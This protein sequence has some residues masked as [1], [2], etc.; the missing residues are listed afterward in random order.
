MRVSAFRAARVLWL[1]VPL[2]CSSS[3]Q[4]TPPPAPAPAEALVLKPNPNSVLSGLLSFT[5]PGATSARIVSSNP[6]EQLSTPY[7]AVDAEGRGQIAV[8][9]LA[10][11]TAYV[12]GVQTM[13]TAGATRTEPVTAT[14]TTEPL[15]PEI[16]Q[17]TI[18]I[19]PG[20][21]KPQQGYYVVSGAGDDSYAVDSSGAIRWYRA[22]GQPSEECKMQTDGTFTSYVGSSTGSEPVPGTYVRYTSDG[23]QIASYPAASP[24]T[25]EPGNPVVYTDPH[26]MLITT[27]AMG[28]EHIHLLAYIQRPTSSTDA[29]LTAT[30]ELL[31]QADDGTVEFRWKSWPHFSID[32]QIEM[33]RAADLDHA[34]AIA[35]DPGDGNYIVSL[36][37]LDALVKVDYQSGNV[38][39]QLGGKQNQFTFV[40]DPLGGFQGQ[41]SVRV[42]PNGNLLIYDNGLHHTPPESRAV[43]Y[44][45]DLSAMTATFV[46]QFRHTPPLVTQFVGSVERLESGN[47]LVAFGW[48]GIVDEVDPQGNVVWEGQIM[49]GTKQQNAYRVRRLP[50]LYNFQEP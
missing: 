50:S 49:N 12:H 14:A 44:A 25:T 42:L 32:D 24:D 26:E 20:T 1:L 36:R 43:E 48:V 18:A 2:S 46:W 33:D 31:R 47:T 17:V 38:I 28:K 15:P 30:H 40:G 16:A 21:G 11:S 22:F 3:P 45:L 10:A 6:A 27:D 19:T 8:V 41:H 39:W 23:S 35:I 4:P 7:T 5:I 9:G 37:N 34:N 29:T 13:T